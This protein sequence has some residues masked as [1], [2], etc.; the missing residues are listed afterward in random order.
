LL[1]HERSTA[2]VAAARCR[3][4][5]DARRAGRER[6][7]RYFAFRDCVVCRRLQEFRRTDTRGMAKFL[8]D[9]VRCRT[10]RRVVLAA[11]LSDHRLEHAG[12]ILCDACRPCRGRAHSAR[13]RR[14][15]SDR[16]A[17][18]LCFH[19][20]RNTAGAPLL[21]AQLFQTSAHDLSVARARH[22]R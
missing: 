3:F 1:D 9:P 15:S 7:W 6:D 21:P 12:C 5:D 11:D 17:G 10:H 13:R 4:D 22:A 8:S 20:L 14:L 2:S 19:P 18:P 16:L